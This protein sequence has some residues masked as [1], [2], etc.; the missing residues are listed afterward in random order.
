ML[1]K[2]Y[3]EDHMNDDYEFVSLLPQVCPNVECR[4]PMEMSDALTTL[5][6]SNPRCITRVVKRLTSMMSQ[7]GVKGVGKEVAKAFFYKFRTRNPLLIFGY[8]Y[9]DSSTD[10]NADGEIGYG[11][12]MKTSEKIYEQLQDRRKYTLWEYIRLANLPNIQSGALQIFG[13][14]DSLDKAYDDIHKGGIGFIQEKIGVEK[15]TGEDC[16][17][18]SLRALKIYETLMTYESDLRNALPFF[19]I[20]PVNNEGVKTVSAVCSDEVGGR[21]HSKTE[22]YN[23]VNSNTGDGIHINFMPSVTKKVDY[24]I[25][26]GAENSSFEEEVNSGSDYISISGGMMARVTSKVKK[27]LKYNSQY[28]EKEQ[29]GTLT[30]KDKLI[31]IVTAEQFLEIMNIK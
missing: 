24:L 30:D 3:V 8:V 17:V 22:F 16:E 28:R 11:V 21:F 5:H 2:D 14:Y 15:G 1:V 12:G 20:V 29:S 9:G 19:E 6:C 7:I 31:G 18:I 4:S 10:T 27:V 13:G 25:W 23:Y 26:N